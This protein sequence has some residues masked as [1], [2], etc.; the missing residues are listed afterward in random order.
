MKN[1]TPNKI[2][3]KIMDWTTNLV[4]D[5]E[6]LRLDIKYDYW[7]GGFCTSG[8]FFTIMNIWAAFY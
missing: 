1:I 5:Y 3:Q 4:T 8:V 2:Y 7:F 6:P